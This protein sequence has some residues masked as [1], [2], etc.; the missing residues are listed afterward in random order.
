[1][2]CGGLS[3]YLER[4]VT[5]RADP[6]RPA[7]RW[8][9][10]STSSRSQGEGARHPLPVVAAFLLCAATFAYDVSTTPFHA[11]G[12][13]PYVLAVLVSYRH[14]WPGVPFVIAGLSTVLALAGPPLGGHPYTRPLLVNRSVI[15]LVLWAAAWLVWR[16]RQA[17]VT[18]TDHGR[19]L[20]ELRGERRRLRLFLE[21][22]PAILWAVDRGLHFTQS[23][24]AGL[25]EL[26]L[27]SDQVLGRTL[28]EF[29]GTDD[30]SFESIAAHRRVL[31]TGETASFET[32]WNGRHYR[33][34][35]EPLPGPGARPA[36]VVGLALDVS[37]RLRAQESARRSEARYRRLFE[38][39]QEA[40]YFAGL[41]GRIR[42]ANRAFRELFGLPAGALEGLDSSE[43]YADPDERDRLREV[44]LER[45]FVR[46]FELRMRYRDGR[47]IRALLSAT[48][49]R[50][51]ADRPAGFQGIL[52]DVTRQ[53][54]LE[55]ELRRRA[56][57]DTLTDLPNRALL[58]D[59]LEVALERQARERS[60]VALL[61]VDLDGF[62]R[63]N[64]GLGHQAGDVV[65]QRAAVRLDEGL[66]GADTVARVGGDEFM[67]L[68]TDVVEPGEA[69]AAAG[70]LTSLFERPFL[71]G[72][73]EVHLAASV[74][75]VYVGPGSGWPESEPVDSDRLVRAADLALYRAKRRAGSTYRLFDPAEDWAGGERD[76][77]AL[78]NEIREG[79]AAG[80][81]ECRYQPVVGFDEGGVVG[82]EVLARW[83]HG[84]RGLL[85]PAEFIDVCE[86][87]GLIVPLGEAILRRACR[88]SAS[89]RGPGGNLLPIFV[90]L[91]PREFDD[92]ELVSRVR[93]AL[94]DTG[95]DPGRL[96]FEVTES[97]AMLRPEHTARL[98]E[99]GCR[100]A[101]DD[102]GTGYASLHYLKTLALDV[103][104]LDMT[105]THGLPDDPADV[106]I[107]RAV[108]TLGRHLGL[109]VVAEGIETAE[110]LQAAREV[111]CGRGQGF[112]LG[113]PEP[114]EEM[115]RRLAGPAVGREEL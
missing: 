33:V 56:L 35:L 111:G 82:V 112:F 8:I 47:S 53:R 32:G 38:D 73:H 69:A 79:L 34:Y 36:G 41:D 88:E 113:R 104:K 105:F 83:R 30:P 29:F 12:V 61:F 28:Q 43:L 75:V 24:G 114:P 108:A 27:E 84:E 87:T 71:A 74:G 100:V 31:E 5:P 59:R 23:T 101:L 103:L 49:V 44:L 93:A 76:R 86:E 6:D 52:R 22:V 92:P 39:V 17:K 42:E 65:L 7:W 77:L 109:A 26:G 90:N 85:A 106:A 60:G 96:V 110:Q 89:W 98:R 10:A 46:D 15:V 3:S 102:F 20:E 72:I 57:H 21:R 37:E 62:K 11:L 81:F 54:E 97:G 48:V 63:V 40:V 14:R 115:A 50:D 94:E 78:E 95:T 107:C 51:A 16:G 19:A 64:D 66:R 70:R 18:A 9:L 58:H 25:S 13:V 99:L 1:M 2:S 91:S 45:G 4:Y 68:L 67:V 55:A 80:A